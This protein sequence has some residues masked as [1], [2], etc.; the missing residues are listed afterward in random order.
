MWAFANCNCPSGPP[1]RRTGP[2][3]LQPVPRQRLDDDE[4][5]QAAIHARGVP[6]SVLRL[7]C[8]GH[9]HLGHDVHCAFDPGLLL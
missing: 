7:L 9:E 8:S 6:L 2:I 1:R 3:C 5:V 4:G